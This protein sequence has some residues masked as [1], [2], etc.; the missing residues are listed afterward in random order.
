ML[1]ALRR[2]W[3]FHEV[4]RQGKR[5]QDTGLILY[6]LAKPEQG[7]R[8]GIVC[9]RKVGNAVIRNRLRRLVREVLRLRW[10]TLRP[11]FNLVVVLRPEA[12]GL[13]LRGMERQLGA[14][15]DRAEMGYGDSRGNHL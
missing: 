14:L 10:S 5:W 12:V 13:D 9:S 7:L 6:R 15:L 3:E 2:E 11:G 4:Y 1:P 8:V